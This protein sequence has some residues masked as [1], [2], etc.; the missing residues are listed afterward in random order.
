[1]ALY[2]SKGEQVSGF[3]RP[4]VRKR[5]QPKIFITD[6]RFSRWVD[7][8][9]IPIIPSGT[10]GIVG[11]IVDKMRNPVPCPP[12]PEPPPSIHY[13]LISTYMTREKG[14]AYRKR[15][16]EWFAAHPPK[17]PRV[18]AILP[19]IDCAP[20]LALNAKYKNKHPPVK[21]T[22]SAMR[23]AGY[24]EA[25]IERSIKWNEKMDER[26]GEIQKDLDLIFGKWP[27]AS[28][29]TPKS[30]PKKIKAVKKKM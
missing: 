29:P 26:S 4:V 3:I 23:L 22:E 13:E 30:R 24:S 19:T 25:Q 27:S 7:D 5:I 12:K 8:D 15:A 10:P 18:S 20:L 28:K 1:M 21:E 16:E 11:Y 14:E 2:N 17:A 6:G 9:R